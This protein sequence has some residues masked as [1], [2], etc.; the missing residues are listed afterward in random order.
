M[1]KVLVLGFL[2]VMGMQSSILCSGDGNAYSYDG[3]R[4][5]GQ[6]QNVDPLYYKGLTDS[7]WSGLLNKQSKGS[8]ILYPELFKEE[9]ER[10]EQVAYDNKIA[11]IQVD[12]TKRVINKNE[13]SKYLLRNTDI[14]ADDINKAVSELIENKDTRLLKNNKKITADSFQAMLP[15][16]VETAQAVEAK[17]SEV[18]NESDATNSDESGLFEDA[19]EVVEAAPKTAPTEQPKATGLLETVK[20]VFTPKTP[21][22]IQQDG[23]KATAKKIAKERAAEGA[24]APKDAAKV[25][26]DAAKI[27][28][29]ATARARVSSN[30]D[31][32]AATGET[33]GFKSRATGE[34]Y[35]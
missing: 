9:S 14:T 6:A 30:A 19:L 8:T 7:E 32:R 25:T 35:R 28:K 2:V 20:S 21:E 13:I 18:S 23:I 24:K 10:R 26:T 29:N 11:K 4:G 22:Q 12:L 16:A 3:S 27:D 17:I 15:K 5:G 34:Y 33:A 1:K 31:F